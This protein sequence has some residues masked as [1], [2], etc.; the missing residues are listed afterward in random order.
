MLPDCTTLPA[1][2]IFAAGLLQND[3]LCAQRVYSS[4]HKRS[5]SQ[6]Q[7]TLST[8]KVLKEGGLRLGGRLVEVTVARL[9]S[10]SFLCENLKGVLTFL[11]L[12]S[13]EMH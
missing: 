1:V 8:A 10:A 4:H 13:C 12:K 2:R 6:A 3:T 5:Y 9:T 11:L 7:P